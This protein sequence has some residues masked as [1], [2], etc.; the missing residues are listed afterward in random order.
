M[1]ITAAPTTTPDRVGWCIEA[2]SLAECQRID[3][4][5][6]DD[7]RLEMVQTGT[8]AP[9]TWSG[10]WNQKEG[11]YE[12]TCRQNNKKVCEFIMWSD[13]TTGNLKGVVHGG[14]Y[15]EDFKIVR[16]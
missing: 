9:I 13:D 11:G 2:A 3:I 14:Q 10:G 16:R 12:G 7:H 4:R 8:G 6:K 5:R 1:P 15:A